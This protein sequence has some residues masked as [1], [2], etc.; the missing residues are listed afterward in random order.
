V[1]SHSRKAYSE[2][3]WRQSTEDFIRCLENAFWHFGGVPRT[4]VV[5]NLKAAVI[6]ADWFDP[7]LNPKIREFCRHYGTAILPTKPRTPRHKGKIEAGVKYVQSNALKGRTF[8]SLA[9]QNRH[10]LDWEMQTADTRI[11]GTIHRQV[12]KTF[13]EAE[14]PALLPLPP[15]RFPSFQKAQGQRHRTTG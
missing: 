10:L 8:T 5:D 11:H 14:R 12:K 4:L 13:E 6:K 9:D 1:L 3:V 7:E 15:M 2:V